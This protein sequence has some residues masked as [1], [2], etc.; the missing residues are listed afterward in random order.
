MSIMFLAFFETIAISWLYGVRRLCNNVK[1]MTGRL[2]SL[3]FRFCW[4][5]AAPLLIM[6]ST[7]SMEISKCQNLIFEIVRVCSSS[8]R[9]LCFSWSSRIDTFARA[10][11]LSSLTFVSISLSI[12]SD[13]VSDPQDASA[14]S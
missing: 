4:F 1:E 3:Y 11:S 2:P 5:L 6:V 12:S 13:A 9:T 7:K 14:F 8:R 10:S